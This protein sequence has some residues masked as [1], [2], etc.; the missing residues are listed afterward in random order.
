YILAVAIHARLAR[1]ANLP[2]LILGALGIR[3]I[4]GQLG[5]NSGWARLAGIAWLLIPINLFQAS[6]IYVDSG[7]ASCIIALIALAAASTQMARDGGKG[8]KP[9]SIALGCAMG[10]CIAGKGNGFMVV[11]TTAAIILI[12]TRLARRK[13]RAAVSA[14]V[15]ALI[16]GILVGGYWPI[17]NL[18]FGGSPLY[19]VGLKLAGHVIFPGESAA[20]TIRAGSMTPPEL[21]GVPTFAA[22]LYTWSQIGHA[23][24][25]WPKTIYG[26]DNRLGGLGWIWLG[27]CV[28]AILWSWWQTLKSRQYSA[29]I[30]VTLVVAVNFALWPLPWWSRY[31]VWI[32]ALG[33]PCLAL[34]LTAL[35]SSPRRENAA[36]GKAWA[37]AALSVLVVE[38]VLST[39]ASLLGNRDYRRMPRAGLASEAA[40]AGFYAGALNSD[41]PIALDSAL[42]GDQ[43]ETAG[44]LLQPPGRRKVLPFARPATAA[45]LDAAFAAGVGFVI[46]HDSADIEGEQ[47][48]STYTAMNVGAFTI[49]APRSAP[50]YLDGGGKP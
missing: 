15:L 26:Y 44:P 13:T 47:Q 16:L 40:S 11:S 37:Y 28:P 18:Y 48:G 5:A 6:M 45:A 42:T 33:L 1:L 36:I 25:R 35:A 38:A 32:Y 20:V 39:R 19:P 8:W 29:I 31:V 30:L 34:S 10:L 43:L 46:L 27:G 17:R 7:F 24:L 22:V 49:V 9:I 50:G 14:V 41:A 2:F 21:R 3:Q 12:V 23:G 4:A